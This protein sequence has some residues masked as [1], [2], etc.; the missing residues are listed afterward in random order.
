[1]ADLG[2]Q[3]IEVGLALSAGLALTWW[4]WVPSTNALSTFTFISL[5]I[6]LLVPRLR[7]MTT[8][9]LSRG[10]EL[11]RSCPPW[12]VGLGIFGVTVAELGWW[13][14]Q[15]RPPGIMLVHDES[16]YRLGTLLLASGKLWTGGLWAPESFESF[17]I[18]TEKVYASIYFPG[19]AMLHVPGYWLGLPAQVT[20]VVL[21][22]LS[23]VAIFALVRRVGGGDLGLLAAVL[24]W[25]SSP[26]RLHAGMIMSQI[27]S[28]LM[29]TLA[30]LAMLEWRERGE[31][32]QAALIGG[33]CGGLMLVRPQDGAFLL[34]VLACLALPELRRYRKRLLKGVAIAFAG[35]SPFLCLMLVQNTGLTGSPWKAA[36]WEYTKQMQPGTGFLSSHS[37]VKPQTSVQQKIDLATEYSEIQKAS[38][39]ESVVA[40]IRSRGQM[41]LKGTLPSV[42]LVLLFP[43]GICAL[44]RNS[45]GRGITGV[46]LLYVLIYG[47][48]SFYMPPYAIPVSGYVAGVIVMSLRSLGQMSA[49]VRNIAFMFVAVTSIVNLPEI[50]PAA[51]Q[52]YPAARDS[53]LAVLAEATLPNKPAVL[54]I[55]YQSGDDFHDEPVYNLGALKL[56]DQSVIRAHDLG[57]SKRLEVLKGLH[58]PRHVYILE[59]RTGI[60]MPLGVSDQILKE[61][62]GR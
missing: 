45:E 56:E 11:L 57:E 60:V 1:M 8:G 26:F 22:G 39:D 21:A 23:L 62:S 59:R 5:A 37:D 43:L 54:F 13:V 20:S 25:G 49:N 35:I 28:L 4:L 58:S 33:F 10:T 12:K 53:K 27:P 34:P 7:A 48:F 32:W 41:L 61:K 52:E 16:S 18:L 31:W 6:V 9:W 51:K 29:G 36:Y 17:H 38:V 14:F 44:V 55:R 50:N 47:S 30:F 3:R 2:L 46:L 24:V 15:H 42:G 40:N 19:T